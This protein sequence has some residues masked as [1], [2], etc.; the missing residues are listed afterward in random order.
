MFFLRST[1]R[2]QDTGVVELQFNFLSDQEE[3]ISREYS[4]SGTET[5]L[6]GSRA[7]Q[8][9]QVQPLIPLAGRD[10]LFE[11]KNAQVVGKSGLCFYNDSIVWGQAQFARN[12]NARYP[13]DSILRSHNANAATVADIRGART[14]KVKRALSLLDSASSH[15][16][17]FAVGVIPRLRWLAS[18]FELTDT[19][20]LVD[21]NL[22]KNFVELVRSYVPQQP[23]IPVKRGEVVEVSS[24]LLPESLRWFP[25]DYPGIVQQWGPERAMK[26]PEFEFCFKKG[27]HTENAQRE[28]KVRLLRNSTGESPWREMLNHDQIAEV[29]DRHTFVR[30]EHLVNRSLELC[31]ALRRATHIVTDDGSISFNLLLAGITDKKVIFLGHP[32][33]GHF[34]EWFTPGYLSLFRNNVDVVLG[35]SEDP[36]SKFSEWKV[37]PELLEERVSI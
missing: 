2:K 31:D 11:I 27:E 14:R 6:F 13:N 23:I 9:Q 26:I 15:F 22:P 20:L 19:S 33:M 10:R 32:G 7:G 28:V 36:S 21:A 25:D 12:S 24:L 34:Q 35:S 4:F 30:I 5:N 16:G 8:V 37:D 29:L 1:K 18:D 17:H 3:L